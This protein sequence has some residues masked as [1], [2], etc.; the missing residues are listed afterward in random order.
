MYTLCSV[1]KNFIYMNIEAEI[2][3]KFEKL[4]GLN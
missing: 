3:Q 2:G 4:Y 1:Y